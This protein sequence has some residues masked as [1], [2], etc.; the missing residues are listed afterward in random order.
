MATPTWEEWQKQFNAAGAPPAPV[1]PNP[2]SLSQ[3]DL[4][5]VSTLFDPNFGRTETMTHAA[6]DAA[7]GGWGG[8]GFAA[9]HGLKLLDSE[10]KANFLLGHQILEPYL[11]REHEDTLNASNNA[12]RLQQIAAEGA[13]ALQRLQLSESG[14]MARLNAQ[15]AAEL[16]R[17]IISG[18]QAMQL[19]TVKEAGETGRERERI[20]GG[21]A[22]DLIK[23]SLTTSG[24]G[25]SGGS[26]SPRPGGAP[27]GGPLGPTWNPGPWGAY[28]GKGAE[29]NP[30]AA[31]N[32]NAHGVT[33]GAGAI[34]SSV[35][36][37]LKKY[38]LL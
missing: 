18:Q 20:G 13:Q 8:G 6:E 10:K 5:N 3:A 27:T 21:I 24:G 17:Q 36:T 7:G 26:G 12:A 25:G 16:Q 30:D 11:A 32:P 22:S 4:G 28:F 19:L 23:Y 35:D 15:E 1:A 33:G 34:G 31:Y 9:G 29:S 14:A 2:G 37:I 38:G